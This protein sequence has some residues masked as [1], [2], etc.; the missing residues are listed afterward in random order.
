MTASVVILHFLPALSRHKT[1]LQRFSVAFVSKTNILLAVRPPTSAQLTSLG[2]V[3]TRVLGDRSPA[4][5]AAPYITY[6]CH[7]S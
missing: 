1:P 7:G 3:S 5:E 2:V 4:W 6:S